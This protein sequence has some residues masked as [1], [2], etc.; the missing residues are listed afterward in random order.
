MLK[1]LYSSICLPGAALNSKMFTTYPPTF[2]L[3]L[4]ISPTSKEWN[5]HLSWAHP[6]SLIMCVC[7]CVCVC[8]CIG[9]TQKCESDHCAMYL[10]QWP[11]R[12]KHAIIRYQKWIR[13]P[14]LFNVGLVASHTHKWYYAKD[15][16]IIFFL[17]QAPVNIT[18]FVK[19]TCYVDTYVLVCLQ[20]QLLPCT[21]VCIHRSGYCK[22]WSNQWRQ[23]PDH[24]RLLCE[25]ECTTN[26]D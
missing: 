26:N 25:L 1:L 8:V 21:Y 19:D 20:V 10:P 15:V 24:T 14:S 4:C 11:V 5:Y 2:D 6:T 17:N 16:L 13:S 7:V 3:C 18:L 23:I 12:F 22:V 9:N